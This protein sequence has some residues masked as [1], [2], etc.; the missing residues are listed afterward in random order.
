VEPHSRDWHVH[1]H[2]EVFADSAPSLSKR[3]MLKLLRR[4]M[5]VPPAALESEI[6]RRRISRFVAAD[7][8]G[9]KIA[10]R[11]NDHVHLLPK[12]SRRNGHFLGSLR[13]SASSVTAPDP[14][15]RSGVSRLTFEVF[16]G[17]NVPAAI[18]QAYLVPE[19]GISII[20]DIDDTLKETKVSCKRTLL[21]NTFLHEFRTIP[22]MAELFRTWSA[23]GAAVHYVSSSP[24]QLYRHLADHLQ[25]EGFPEG[26]F[27]LRAFRL[28]DHL[29]RRLLMLRRSG[30]A[31]VIRSILRTFPQRKFVLVGDSGEHDPEIYGVMARKYPGQVTGVFIRQVEGPRDTAARYQRAFRGVPYEVVRLFRDPDELADAATLEG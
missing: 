28:R 2:G 22:G 25:D 19:R 12:A 29:I 7:L 26:S 24:W 8:A 20:S 1:V 6:F 11:V 17:D 3:F 21:A 15:H 30:K 5:Q 13:L 4:A 23:Q 16:R 10:V 31:T 18:G 9:R 27:H 14:Q